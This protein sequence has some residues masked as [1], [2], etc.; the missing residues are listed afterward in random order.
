MCE[1]EDLEGVIEKLLKKQAR[2]AFGLGQTE[3]AFRAAEEDALV[4]GHSPGNAPPVDGVADLE[5]LQL[6]RRL[7]A[8]A[9]FGPGFAR[10]VFVSALGGGAAEASGIR[11]IRA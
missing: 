9:G 10:C 3:P 6:Q 7:I 4:A 8:P 11:H 2:V 1:V 5:K